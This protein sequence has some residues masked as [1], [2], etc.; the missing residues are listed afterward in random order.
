M[1]IEA[2]LSSLRGSPSLVLTPLTCV[3]LMVASLISPSYRQGN[4]HKAVRSYAQGRGGHRVEG[5]LGPRAHTLDL[6]TRSWPQSSSHHPSPGRQATL[7]LLLY[8]KSSS[9]V[10]TFKE[11]KVVPPKG[12]AVVISILGRTKTKFRLTPARALQ[13]L[14]DTSFVFPW[15]PGEESSRRLLL[16]ASKYKAFDHV[17]WRIKNNVWHV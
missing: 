15:M 7:T 12:V 4:R 8:R 5:R 17:L 13:C 3:M 11:K 16:A 6:Y 1:C 10:V 14:Y 9:L 2:T